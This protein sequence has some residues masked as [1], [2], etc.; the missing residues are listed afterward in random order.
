M[1]D[2]DLYLTATNEV[3]SNQKD[4][5]LWAKALTLAEGDEPKA[6]YK[7]INLRIEQLSSAETE[8]EVTEKPVV[9]KNPYPWG[10]LSIWVLLIFIAAFFGVRPP[11]FASSGDA[12][13][14][15]IIFAAIYAVIGGVIIGTF[16]YFRR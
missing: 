13:G 5:A 15:K 11:E 2:E 7:Y 6:R 8:A 1:G 4:P 9:T 10:L 14:Y 3:D 12:I 16:K